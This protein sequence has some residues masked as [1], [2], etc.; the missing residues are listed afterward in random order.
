LLFIIKD[1]CIEVADVKVARSSE[2][3]II[4][5]LKNE[6]SGRVETYLGVTE[7]RDHRDIVGV[8]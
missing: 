3:V 2:L 4:A 7:V 8:F 1:F 5:T 6:A